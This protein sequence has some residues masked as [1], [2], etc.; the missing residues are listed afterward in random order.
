MPKT[1]VVPELAEKDIERLDA[2]QEALLAPVRGP[3]RR[4]A[5]RHAHRHTHQ[6]PESD[7]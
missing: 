6:R 7:T 5:D 2:A 3:D 1:A 4:T